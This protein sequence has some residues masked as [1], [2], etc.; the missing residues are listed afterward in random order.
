MLQ[1]V[2]VCCSVLQCVAVCCSVLQCVEVCRSVSQCIAVCRSV[3]QCVAVCCSLMQSAAVCCS[4]L[5]SIVVCTC[6]MF[7]CNDY[8]LSIHPLP[9]QH[10]GPKIW[11]PVSNIAACK[12]YPSPSLIPLIRMSTGLC[13]LTSKNRTQH[14]GRGT[15][16][17]LWRCGASG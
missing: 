15:G 9:P 7:L 16:G 1:C 11:V 6:A 17:G 4:L 2:A 8:V 5:Q 14:R 10:L 13:L 3:L 12:N